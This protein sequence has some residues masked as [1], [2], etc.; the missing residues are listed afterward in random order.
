MKRKSTNHRVSII[1]T[2][3]GMGKFVKQA[4]A[5]VLAQ[6]YM[7][8]ELIIAR[9]GKEYQG[10][11]LIGGIELSFDVP[12]NV[13]CRFAY[14]INQAFK[15]STGQYITYL[16]HDDLYLPYRLQVMVKVMEKFNLDI[17]FGSQQLI[18]DTDPNPDHFW[19]AV[20]EGSTEQPMGRV[21]H[22]SLMHKR[23]CFEKVGGWDESAPMRYGDAF[24]WKRLLDAGYKFNGIQQ[25]L[26]VHRFNKE[27]VTWKEEHPMTVQE[28]PCHGRCDH[29]GGHPMPYPPIDDMGNKRTIESGV[30]AGWSA[31]EK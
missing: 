13:V 24:F 8:Y 6:T 22:S 12:K 4:A 5:S 16:C 31:M 19:G 27:S 1:L 26:D 25:V 21:D 15:Y 3:H 11:G 23:E 7:D 17:V 2:T 18:D 28:S 20:R 29:M 9:D 10:Y 14:T 30:D